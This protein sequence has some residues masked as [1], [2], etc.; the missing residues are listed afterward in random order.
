MC[1]PFFPSALERKIS[2]R[3]NRD[4][5]VQK[6]ILLPESPIN[7]GMYTIF[8]AIIGLRLRYVETHSVCVIALQTDKI[9][10]M[11]QSTNQ[12][13]STPESF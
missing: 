5:L 1:F 7:L 11:S 13:F 9:H 12:K 3:A 8:R 2:I 6:G 10:Q 4:V